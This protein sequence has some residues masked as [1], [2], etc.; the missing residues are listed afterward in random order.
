MYA[1]MHTKRVCQK[2]HQW[3]E[4][5]QKKLMNLTPAGMHIKYQVIEPEREKHAV[6]TYKANTCANVLEM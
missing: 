5:L 2:T 3:N 1:R 6:K 4:Y